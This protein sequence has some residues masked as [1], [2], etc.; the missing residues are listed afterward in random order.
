VLPNFARDD[1]SRVPG[2]TTVKWRPFGRGGCRARALSRQVAAALRGRPRR[3][4]AGVA[5][6]GSAADRAIGDPASA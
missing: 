5:A 1:R 6:S 4:G 3:P 2:T